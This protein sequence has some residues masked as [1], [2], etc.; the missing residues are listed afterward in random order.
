MK[1]SKGFFSLI[2]VASLAF[3]TAPTSA[4]TIPITNTVVLPGIT[5][6][7][8][9]EAGITFGD[10]ETATLNAPPSMLP[11]K[12]TAQ[13]LDAGAAAAAAGGS[14]P[15]IAIS[16]SAGGDVVG[17]QAHADAS[18]NYYLEVVGPSGAPVP[19]DLKSSIIGTLISGSADGVVALASASL[20]VV[21]PSGNLVSGSYLPAPPQPT[22]VDTVIDLFP[23]TIYGVSLQALA[24]ALCGAQDEFGTTTCD[25]NLASASAAVDPTFMIDPGFADASQYQIVFSP[26]VSSAVPESGT[27]GMMLIGFAGLGYAAFRQGRNKRSLARNLAM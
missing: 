18:L 14:D 15:A 21:N 26:G 2:A 24:F 27:W 17:S 1:M 11:L 25:G 8:Y 16:V 6:G 10:F 13:N 22:T 3:S 19:V 23:N 20:V 9:A 5:A 4:A 7:V 12:A